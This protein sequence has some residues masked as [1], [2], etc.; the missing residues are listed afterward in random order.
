MSSIGQAVGGIVGGTIGFF[1][2]GPA[3]ALRGAQL[4]IMAGGLIDPPK[5]P[6]INGPR[7]NDLSTQTCSYGTFIPRNYGTIAQHGNVFWVQGDSLIEVSSQETVGGKGAPEQVANTW[8]YYATFAVSLCRGPIDGVRR[9]WIGGQ[10]WYDAGSSEFDTVVAS[11]A[12][13]QGFTLY[14]GTDIQTADPLIQADRGAANVP[15]WRGRAYIVFDRLPLEKYGNSLM[16]AQVNVEILKDA[17]F[18]NILIRS[19]SIP[20]DSAWH[21]T[22]K[23]TSNPYDDQGFANFLALRAADNIPIWI[24]YIDGNTFTRP[25]TDAD[26]PILAGPTALIPA[27]GGSIQSITLSLDRYH[28]AFATSSDTV[29]FCWGWH[30]LLDA[31]AA[32]PGTPKSLAER[33]GVI[34]VTWTLGLNYWLGKIGGE[35]GSGRLKAT[36]SRVDIYPDDPVL[37]VWD[38]KAVTVLRTTTTGITTIKIYDE[39]DGVL[40]VHDSFTVSLGGLFTLMSG[41]NTAYVENDL[42]YVVANTNIGSS[43]AVVVVIDLVNQALVSEENVPQSFAAITSS[44]NGAVRVVDGVVHYGQRN[45]STATDGYVSNSWSLDRIT[46]GST[47]LGTIVETECLLSGLL[48]AGDLDVTDLT[49]SVRGYRVV[50]PGAIRGALEPL[51]AVW[52]FD[53][54]QHGYQIKFKRRG[55]SSV[56]TVTAGELD[57]ASAGAEPGVQVTDMREM[58]LMLPRR[59]IVNYIDASREYENNAQQYDRSNTDSVSVQSAELAIVLDADEA[60]RAAER[61]CYLRWIERNDVS[62]TLPPGYSHLEPGDVITVSTDD[63]TYTLRLASINTT[64]DGRIECR[65]KYHRAAL[66]T[67]IASGEESLGASDVLSLP[68]PCVYQLLDIPLMRDDDDTAGFP[69][70]VSGYTASWPGG[71]L[72]R[73]DDGGQSWVD[74]DAFSPG[75][76]IGYATNSLSTHGGTL[77]D[78]ASA[79]SVRL[80]SGSLG[81]VTEAQMFAGQNWFAYGAHGRWEIIAAR[82]ATLQVDGSY[83]ITDLLRGQHGTEWATSQHAVGDSVVLLDP[84]SLAFISVNSGIIGSALLYRAVT[85]GKSLSSDVDYSYTYAGVNLECLSPVNLTGNRHPSTNDWTLAW[86]R[87]SRFVEWRDYVDA[88]L[89]ETSESYEIDIYADGTYAT[90]KRTLTATTPTVAYTSAQQVTDFGSNQATLYVKVYQLSATVGRGYPLTTSITR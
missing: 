77:Y 43:P 6:E 4:G 84:N 13:A 50:A 70:V 57:A 21:T 86:T 61:L 24:R 31:F 49:D 11:N 69:A 3:W 27:W 89:G 8:S 12:A 10:L 39:V 48:D 46:S 16:G 71:I 36:S 25:I 81:S 65:A 19:F 56:A 15:A 47:T 52:P 66:Y 30:G 59:M 29:Y 82:T 5:G 28:Y 32:G 40:G 22:L 14:N 85:V 90:L 45:S 1:T 67:S 42:L 51:R 38:G 72:Y 68:G 88:R 79:L 34:Y 87:R 74:L 64:P 18:D 37:T 20:T 83:V 55:S 63:S 53:V 35:I 41:D 44:R 60:A 76:V 58:D 9:I 73:S 17:A 78:F 23:C 80:Y 54:V 7:L 62:L 26:D 33:D 2:G 75:A